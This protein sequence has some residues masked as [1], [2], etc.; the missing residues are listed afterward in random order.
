MTNFFRPRSY[1]MKV[2]PTLKYAWINIPKNGSS[3]IQKVLDDNAWNDV[4]DDLI[5]SIA[6]S[7]S[8]KKLVILRDPVERWISGFAQSI[9]D[10]GNLKILDLLDNDMFIKTIY[11]NPVYD[12]HTEY[13]H[14]FIGNAKNLEYIY[15]QKTRPNEF[16]RLFAA[17]IRNTSGTADFDNWQDPINPA[18]NNANKLAINNKLSVQFNKDKVLKDL[19]K[20]DYELFEKYDR[21]TN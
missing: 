7:P 9:G 17:W 8:V 10:T 13:Q 20:R 11:M 1:A 14:R 19:H 4:P 16:Y 6:E 12:D 15:M 2:D 5:N 21:F 3:F 18:S